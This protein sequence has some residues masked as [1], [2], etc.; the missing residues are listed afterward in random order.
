[1]TGYWVQ[2][3]CCIL[4]MRDLFRRWGCHICRWISI[5]NS[6]AYAPSYQPNRWTFRGSSRISKYQGYLQRKQIKQLLLWEHFLKSLIIASISSNHYV[7]NII[8]Q[9]VINSDIL[10]HKSLNISRPYL[11]IKISGLPAKQQIKN[12]YHV[13]LDTN[14]YPDCKVNKI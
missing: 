14:I 5:Y 6:P 9:N 8:M 13:Q 4:N 1:M 10:F 12:N 7:P 3:N 2:L 11:H